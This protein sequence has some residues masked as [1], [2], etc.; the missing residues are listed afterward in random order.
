MRGTLRWPKVFAEQKIRLERQHVTFGDLQQRQL[1]DDLVVG[2]RGHSLDEVDSHRVHL[3]LVQVQQLD[4]V[5]VRV[6][7][8]HDVLLLRVHHIV[9]LV[10]QCR[11]YHAVRSVARLSNTGHTN[12]LLTLQLDL[13]DLFGGGAGCLG[14]KNDGV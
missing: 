3:I 8:V 2:L 1:F 4:L 5:V 13:F 12:A 7:H 11:V 6:Y 14:G 10:E 9:R